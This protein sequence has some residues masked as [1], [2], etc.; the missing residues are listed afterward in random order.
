MVQVSHPTAPLSAFNQRLALQFRR[1]KEPKKLLE[2]VLKTVEEIKQQNLKF[3]R[4]TYSSILA[5][6][7]RNRDQESLFK[8]LKEMEEN[9]LAPS[10]DNYNTVLEV[11][12]FF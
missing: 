8:T 9:D 3:D 12:F 1:N 2:N 11:T 4:N 5:A 7:A 6:Y 10:V